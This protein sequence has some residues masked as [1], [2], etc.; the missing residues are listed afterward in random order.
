VALRRGVA[1][2]AIV[3]SEHSRYSF[4]LSGTSVDTFARIDFFDLNEATVA[5]AYSVDSM[6]AEPAIT[7]EPRYDDLSHGGLSVVWEFRPRVTTSK[8]AAVRHV[9]RP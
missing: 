2:V 3:A 8:G 4:Q 5:P 9:G 1:F 7:N 6:H